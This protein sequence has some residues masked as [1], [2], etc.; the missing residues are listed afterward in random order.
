MQRMSGGGNS[1]Y[2]TIEIVYLL[3]LRINRQHEFHIKNGSVSVWHKVILSRS[4]ILVVINSWNSYIWRLAC[5][6]MAKPTAIGFVSFI[7]I[8]VICSPTE[9]SLNTNTRCKLVGLHIDQ[10]LHVFER[11]LN[12]CVSVPILPSCHT[13]CLRTIYDRIFRI[14][15]WPCGVALHI[16]EYKPPW[17]WIVETL[18]HSVF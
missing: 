3:I 13:D 14:H 9:W 15:L 4:N 1:R 10:I 8:F 2:P 5:S 17:I 6:N 16:L 18:P 11:F 7:F 12:R